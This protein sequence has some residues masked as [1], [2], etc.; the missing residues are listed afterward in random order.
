MY[1]D[2]LKEFTNSKRTAKIP[3]RI[4]RLAAGR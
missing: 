2:Q 3:R 1:R 4:F